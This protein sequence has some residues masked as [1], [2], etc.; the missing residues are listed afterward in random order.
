MENCQQQAFQNAGL[1]VE[2]CTYMKDLLTR[3]QVLNLLFASWTPPVQTEEIPLNEALGRIAAKS[4]MAQYNIPVVRA[5]AMDGVAVR[6]ACP[7]PP[8]GSR[9]KTLSG[10]TLA[11]I[12]MTGL[13]P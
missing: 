9:A 7:I 8:V 5:S 4:Y 3:S 1:L 10:P 13:I 6:S 11:M 12:L 2:R